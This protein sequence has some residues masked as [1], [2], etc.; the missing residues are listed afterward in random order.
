M[1]GLDI[2]GD[3]DFTDFHMFVTCALIMYKIIVFGVFLFYLANSEYTEDCPSEYFDGE[4]GYCYHIGIGRP[5]TQSEAFRYCESKNG[6]L[7]GL[8]NFPLPTPLKNKLSQIAKMRSLNSA[9]WIGANCYQ[10]LLSRKNENEFKESYTR[11]D[12]CITANDPNDLMHRRRP[13]CE[14]LRL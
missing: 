3:K 5:T 9:W 13:I 12:G 2:K 10:L 11:V 7:L 6:K 1:K 4:D 14:M 8:R